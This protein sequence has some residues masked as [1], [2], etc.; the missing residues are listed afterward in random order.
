MKVTKSRAGL[1]SAVQLGVGIKAIRKQ[2]HH[3]GLLYKKED[4]PPRFLHLAWHHRLV[5]EALPPDYLIGFSQLDAMN[6]GYMV[7]YVSQVAKSPSEIPYSISFDGGYYFDDAGNY[8]P[9]PLGMGLTCATFIMTLYEK[10]G[11]QLIDFSTWSSRTDDVIWQREIIDMLR[12]DGAS[13]EHIDVLES[14]I[15]AARVRPEEIAAA[16][17]SEEAPIDFKAAKKL[18]AEILKDVA[19]AIK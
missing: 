14:N 10:N 2:R 3:V 11:L 13:L 4:S 17:I 1:T 16:V 5:D 15:G 12:K 7:A 9:K 8:V 19:K 6:K 18:A